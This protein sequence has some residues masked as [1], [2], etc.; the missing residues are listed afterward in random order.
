MLSQ[1]TAK[2]RGRRKKVSGKPN[3]ETNKLITN[4]QCKHTQN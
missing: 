4:K 2:T 1:L 3:K